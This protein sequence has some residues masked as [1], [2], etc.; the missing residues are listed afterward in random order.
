MTA[1]GI[2]IQNS[3]NILNR[4]FRVVISRTEENDCYIANI[5]SLNTCFA[6][7]DTVEEAMAN[8]H[9]ALEGTLETMIAHGWDIP[10]DNNIM[11]AT[12]T[13]PLPQSLSVT[14]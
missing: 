1:T 7:G 4:T 9:E 10:N 11:E 14:A 8:L 12:L 6:F 2:Q 3:Q 5:P 13:V